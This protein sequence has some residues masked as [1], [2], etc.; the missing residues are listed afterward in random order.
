MDWLWANKE[1]IFSGLG[2]AVLGVFVRLFFRPPSGGPS[3][4]IF[5]GRSSSVLGS[6]VASGSN[7]SQTIS[8]VTTTQLEEPHS[9]KSYSPAPTPS[10]I[11]NQLLALPVFQ[12]KS[13]AHSYLG[14]KVR[15]PAK[16][17]DLEELLLSYRRVVDIGDA[18]HDLHVLADEYHPAR[19]YV[20]IE[21]FPRLKISHEGTAME[22]SGT[23]CYVSEGGSIRLKD[24]EISFDRSVQTVRSP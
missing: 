23:I 4:Q 15:W 10:E 21:R 13:A 14:L 2:V 7:I 8:I 19:M 22:I 5:A 20:N 9:D 3:G 6:P 1:W 17:A 11:R 24:A 18:T 16:L 12:R